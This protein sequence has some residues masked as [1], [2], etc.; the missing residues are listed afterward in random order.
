[1]VEAELLIGH[2]R[3]QVRNLQS[4]LNYLES[5]DRVQEDDYSYSHAKLRELI[6]NLKEL[7]R[8]SAQRRDIHRLRAEWVN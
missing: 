8:F 6:D 2:L 5:R 1:M 4:L 7:E 3:G